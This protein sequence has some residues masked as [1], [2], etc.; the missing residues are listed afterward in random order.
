VPAF[1]KIRTFR[2]YSIFSGFENFET[3]GGKQ[4]AEKQHKSVRKKRKKYKKVKIQQNLNIP[5]TQEGLEGRRK[6]SGGG[7][8]RG[9]KPTNL[10][11]KRCLV[12]Y[13]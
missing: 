13:W 1:Y 11:D 3:Q 8:N 10:F 9:E 4:S 5:Y 12:Q 2:F 6:P 7:K